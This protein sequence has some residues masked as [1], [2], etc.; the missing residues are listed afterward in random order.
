MFLCVTLHSSCDVT[1][2]PTSVEPVIVNTETNGKT[3]LTGRPGVLARIIS[4][5]GAV[6]LPDNL[7]G[8][9]NVIVDTDI[10][11]QTRLATDNLA[12]TTAGKTPAGLWALLVTPIELLNFITV[13]NVNDAVAAM[14]RKT[15]PL[16][17]ALNMAMCEKLVCF[18]DTV[19]MVMKT[20][21]S[22]FDS[23]M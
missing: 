1:S 6:F 11:M 17:G 5:S 4:S 23:L 12:S 8:G 22:R 9:I 10:S 19:Q 16:L 20:I 15:S 21:S 13:K 14:V 3:V 18:R 7:F 2:T